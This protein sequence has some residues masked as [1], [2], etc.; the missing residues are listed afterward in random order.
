M[1]I[2]ADI[3]ENTEN[4]PNFLEKV[5]TCDESFFNTTQK[6]SANSCTGRAPQFTKAKEST[7]EQIQI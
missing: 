3:L 5:M 6:V 4:D 1:N 7:A 2:C